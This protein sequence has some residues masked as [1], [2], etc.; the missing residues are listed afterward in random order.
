MSTYFFKWFPEAHIFLFGLAPAMFTVQC[1]TCTYCT[2]KHKGFTVR[3][4]NN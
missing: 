1:I 3:F 4:S 2:S